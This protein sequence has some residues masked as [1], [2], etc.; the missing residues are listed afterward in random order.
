MF[1]IQCG[2][3]IDEHA[4]F[5]P[6]CGK[7]ISAPQPAEPDAAVQTDGQELPVPEA[8]SSAAEA[9]VNP[10]VPPAPAQDAEAPDKQNK[11]GIADY[12]TYIIALL[13]TKNVMAFCEITKASASGTLQYVYSC[14]MCFMLAV[15]IISIPVDIVKMILFGIKG[16]VKK[17]L[18]VL[19][20]LLLCPIY[21]IVCYFSI[22]SFTFF[23]IALIISGAISW[24]IDVI[25]K[26]KTS[27]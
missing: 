26:L 27:E 24:G 1:C 11:L 16:E 12:V 10:P 7:A 17:L 15:G 21:I 13:C 18:S 2:A 4:K 22:Y 23:V 19:V 8:V 9:P 25:K 20:E 3:A 14:F 6:K 5:C